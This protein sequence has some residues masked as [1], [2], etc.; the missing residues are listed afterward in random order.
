[1]EYQRLGKSG[2]TVS[3]I[4]L[5]CMSFSSSKWEKWVLEEQ[6]SIAMLK[7]TYD[8][9]ITTGTPPTCIPTVNPKSSSA[10]P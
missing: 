10:R 9:G 8:A 5:G 7:A 3:K 4:I 1:M 6:E 2:L